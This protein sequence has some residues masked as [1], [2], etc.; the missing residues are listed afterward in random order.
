[1][2][3]FQVIQKPQRRGAELFAVQLSN[4]LQKLGHTV[5]LIALFKGANELPFS[6]KIITL[7][8]PQK[9][10]WFDWYGYKEIAV[11]IQQ[12]NP[13]IIQCNAGDTLKYAVLSKFLFRW[14]IPIIARNA[15][16]VSQY[17]QNPIVKKINGWLYKKTS[18]IIS[19][20]Q[21][22][23]EDL[24]KLF[25]K[26]TFKTKVIPIGI[27][28]ILLKEVQWQQ[29]SDALLHIVHV[30]GFTFEKN[31]EGLLRIFKDFLKSKPKSHLHLL[32]DGPKKAA[33]QELSK[34]LG[35]LDKITFY[36]FVSN[37]VDYIK[38]A[39]MLVLPSLIEGLPGV[40]LE[41]MY[42]KTPVIAYDVGGISEVLTSQ[43]G[44]L[45]PKND[46][47][48]FVQAMLDLEQYSNKNLLLENAYKM[49]IEHYNNEVLA[50]AFLRSYLEVGDKGEGIREKGE[51]KRQK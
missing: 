28:P 36:G 4:H 46:E 38:K 14:N 20:S 39:D 29:N 26:V 13:D 30:G 25:P 35:I 1:M 5:V 10:R 11:L 45:I 24:I 44:F 22:S 27:E 15:S 7:N 37:P 34:S 16:T 32:G 49:V 48:A 6:G 31:H 42:S 47:V 8:R 51:V 21:H 2:I 43:T 18:A 12:Y 41:A 17:I 33:I 40:I 19:V 3:I 23:K 50:M 9:Y